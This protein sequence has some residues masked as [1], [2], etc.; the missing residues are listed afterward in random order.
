MN[1]KFKKIA[2]LMLLFCILI[3]GTACTKTLDKA[4]DSLETKALETAKE[5]ALDKL[6]IEFV[7]DKLIIIN[8]NLAEL[9]QIIKNKAFTPE[10]EE[11]I[12]ELTKEIKD[13]AQSYMDLKTKDIPVKYEIAHVYMTRAME[14]YIEAA[15]IYPSKRANVDSDVLIKSADFMAEGNENLQKFLEEVKEVSAEPIK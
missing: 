14:N 11:R 2:I 3:S 12:A 7:S 4:E 9:V 13:C 6:Y 1:L 8:D 10:K 5:D 15:N